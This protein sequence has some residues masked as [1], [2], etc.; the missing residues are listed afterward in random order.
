[1]ATSVA[2]EQRVYFKK[3]S[4]TS[5]DWYYIVVDAITSPDKLVKELEKRGYI[6]IE[7]RYYSA[8]WP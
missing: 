2:V 4:L 5:D 7:I 8:S 6:S 1:M 3:E